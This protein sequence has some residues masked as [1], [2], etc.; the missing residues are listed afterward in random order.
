MNTVILVV[1]L[2][3]ARDNVTM[4]FAV[5]FPTEEA[6]QAAAQKHKDPRT[7]WGRAYPVKYAECVMEVK[8]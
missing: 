1:W 6:C 3:T 4:Q 5:R 7:G 8:P 2:L